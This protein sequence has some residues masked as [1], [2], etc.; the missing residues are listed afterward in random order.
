[1]AAN[2][3]LSHYLT[4]TS[5]TEATAT[6][7][8]WSAIVGLGAWLERNIWIEN[9]IGRYYPNHYTMLL[10]ESGTRKSAAI[11]GFR[12]ILRQAGYKTFAAEKTSKEKFLADL[13]GQH[14][15]EDQDVTDINLFGSGRNE[16]AI[17]P[18]L[19]A[20]DEANDFFGINN[21][22][23]LSTL[24]SL[25]DYEGSYENKL[26]G[27][28]SDFIPNPTVSILSGNTSQNFSTAFPTTII[29]QGFFSR[30]LLIYGERTRDKIAWPKLQPPE[31]TA[32]IVQM[33][34]QIKQVMMGPVQL[35]EGAKNLLSAI[36]YL[37]D[38]VSD[39]RFTSYFNRRH[40]HLLKLCTVLSASKMQM[41]LS[42]DSI[43]QANT[44]LTY[45][46]NLMPK[47]L[48]EFGKVQNSDV[49]DKVLR[50]IY[51]ADEPPMLKDIFKYVSRD[52]NG[53]KELGEILQKL[54]FA[55][56]I[57]SLPNIGFLPKR[58]AM[59]EI[60]EGEEENEFVDFQRYLTDEELKVKI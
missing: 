60:P 27:S 42:E 35:T 22:E 12:K 40:T 18:V 28:K 9:G 54:L 44:Y 25:W 23:F 19:I 38:Q 10:G 52:V 14:Q 30:I 51:E 57:Q 15:D 58:V 47:A 20:A 5:D 59:E 49:V 31:A 50:I 55:D 2:D 46:Q 41:A 43:L 33:L 56:K 39:P 29:G 36:Y 53:P 24:G 16:D 13:S 6:F 45:I 32:A 8:R 26:K 1:M 48:G 3:F 7:H 4:Y 17:T 11:K 37:P 34:Q 21:L